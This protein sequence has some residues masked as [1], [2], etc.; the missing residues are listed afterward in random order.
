MLPLSSI[1]MPMVTGTSAWENCVRVWGA[2][3]S[4]TRKSLRLR[5]F[6]TRSLLS[7]T[8]ACRTTS[9]TSTLMV[10][11]LFFLST[12]G[13][14]AFAGFAVWACNGAAEHKSRIRSPPPTSWLR[15]FRLLRRRIVPSSR[16]DLQRRLSFGGAQFYPDAAPAAVADQVRGLISQHVLV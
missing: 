2:P 14:W 12:E 11:S 13:V 3:S 5:S 4:K 16:I 9:L 6:T 1:S 8:V 7:T 10:Y 15:R